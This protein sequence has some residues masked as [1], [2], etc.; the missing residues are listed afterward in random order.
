M[1][2]VGHILEVD[3]QLAQAGGGVLDHPVDY[4]NPEMMADSELHRRRG[5]T[6]SGAPRQAYQRAG[7][8]IHVRGSALQ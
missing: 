6:L 4:G 5:V 1:S 7:Y 8:P 3:L 2:W